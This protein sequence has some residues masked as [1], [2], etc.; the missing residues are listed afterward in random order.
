MPTGPVRAHW[1]RVYPLVP[2]VP[3]G[4]LVILSSPLVI[5][6]GAKN[7]HFAFLG[8]P[9]RVSPC[10]SQPRFFASLRMTEKVR[11][12]ELDAGICV[13]PCYLRVAFFLTSIRNGVPSNPKVARIRFS[14]YRR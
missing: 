13:R 5:L 12:T 7:L 4:P 11:L 14:K 10:L 1:S 8:L 6:S 3:T 9:L 2:C